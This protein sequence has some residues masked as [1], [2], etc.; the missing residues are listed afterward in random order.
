M[1]MWLMRLIRYNMRKLLILGA[2]ILQLP[3]I[4]K[5]KEIGLYVIALD[6]NP[7]SIGFNYS[8]AKE[9]VSTIDISGVL[10]VAKNYNIDGIMTMA[11]DMPI[12]TVAEVSNKLGLVGLDVA[13]AMNATNKAFMRQCLKDS[14]ISIPSFFVVNNYN[15]YL[16]AAK[17]I[18]SSFIVKPADNSGSRGVILVDDLSNEI[19]KKGAFEYSKQYSRS[20]DIIVEEYM[21]GSEVSVEAISIK[22]E[23][24]I[25]AITDKLTTGSPYFVEMGHSQQTTQPS[26]IVD[27][28]KAITI[29]TINSIGIK[30]GPSHTEV[31]L[32]KDGP[33]IVE[34]GARLG[35]DNITSHLVPLSTGIDMVECCIKIAIGD[36]FDISRK[37]NKASAIRYIPCPVGILRDIKGVDEARNVKGVKEVQ[38]IQNIGD[39]VGRI[40][41]SNDRIGYVI[42]QGD[43]VEEAVFA[44]NKGV[45]FINIDVERDIDTI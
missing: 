35:G 34:I 26:N 18:N 42:S 43:T 33:K 13:C 22:G 21:S 23:V 19:C 3:A 36:N 6:M 40:N 45:S 8:D 10:T 4:V 30:D 7:N 5:A 12:R 38:I 27:D 2:S 1:K 11:S 29:D 25:I 17:K 37:Y 44:C 31:M 9:I 39:M 14:N 20:G 32:T 28:I 15:E 24:N 16:S 41:S